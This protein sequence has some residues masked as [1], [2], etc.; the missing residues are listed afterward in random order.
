MLSI[1][2]LT[3]GYGDIEVLHGIDLNVNEGE[4]VA[5]IGAN[6]SGKTTMLSCVSG[7]LKA[8]EGKILFHGE[9]IQNYSPDRIV[10]LG[11]IQVPEGRLLFPKLSVRENLELGAFNKRSRASR[12]QIIEMVFEF[13]PRLKE[14]QHQIAGSLSG[15]EAQMCAIGRGLMSKPKLLMLDEP[16]LGLAPI[17]V[18]EIMKLIKKIRE[19]EDVTVLL[20]EQNVK[21]SLK[22]ADRAF[23][24][25][26]GR[27]ITEG[28]SQDLINSE[29]IRKAYLGI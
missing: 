17:A 20:V 23:V 15:G 4:I 24:L 28:N 19:E 2:G 21:Q 12:N 9:E 1:Q 25:E 8:S 16:S 7:L 26:N 18:L 3:A 22:L 14:R 29:E 27:V 6:S 11:M 13:L 10:D 5:V